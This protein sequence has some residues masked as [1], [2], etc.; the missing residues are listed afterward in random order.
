M[1]TLGLAEGDGEGD[2][3]GLPLMPPF[4]AIATA[5]TAARP[6]N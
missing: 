5:D 6:R 2:G 1:L 3:L 4:A